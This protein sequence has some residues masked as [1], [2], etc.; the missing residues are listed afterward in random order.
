MCKGCAELLLA[1]DLTLLVGQQEGNPSCE[2][3]EY[4]YAGDDAL[5]GTG[6]G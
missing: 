2:K 4:W 6:C 3:A 1:F 5:T